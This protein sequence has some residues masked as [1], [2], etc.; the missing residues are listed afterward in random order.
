[1][2]LLGNIQLVQPS[3]RWENYRILKLHLPKVEVLEWLLDSVLKWMSRSKVADLSHRFSETNNATDG[4]KKDLYIYIYIGFQ[5]L[6]ALIQGQTY[7]PEK[8]IVMFVDLFFQGFFNGQICSDVT[9]VFEP[10]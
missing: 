1:M 3:F 10:P 5:A 4:T 9:R 6:A 2:C 8:V 7:S